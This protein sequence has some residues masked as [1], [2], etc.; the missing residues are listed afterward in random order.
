[1]L[2]LVPR[3]EEG[4]EVLRVHV[5]GVLSGVVRSLRDPVIGV[6]GEQQVANA[7]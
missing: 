4:G 6:S 2:P 5:V 1:M 3:V 7:H